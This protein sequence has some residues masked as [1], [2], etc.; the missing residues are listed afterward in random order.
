MQSNSE[1]S[2][3]GSDDDDDDD[4]DH[5]DH[6]TETIPDSPDAQ[7]PPTE[8]FAGLGLGLSLEMERGINTAET[9]DHQTT[10]EIKAIEQSDCSQATPH[11]H[12]PAIP[13]LPILVPGIEI[14]PAPALTK[15]AGPE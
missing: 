13:Q 8:G 10:N 11:T 5:T 12:A 6:Q 1:D 4:N 9:Q 7:Q 3:S 14:T 2:S 15:A